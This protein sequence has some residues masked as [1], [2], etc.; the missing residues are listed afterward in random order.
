MG[1]SHR[2]SFLTLIWSSGTW[3]GANVWLVFPCLFFGRS[4]PSV[5]PTSTAPI[6]IPAQG[7]T[8][9]TWAQRPVECRGVGRAREPGVPTCTRALR[10]GRVGPHGRTPL[11][12]DGPSAAWWRQRPHLSV[13][14]GCCRTVPSCFSRVRLFAILWTVAC[15]APRSMGILQARTLRW[16]TVPSSRGS[17]RPGGSN[18]CLLRLP[19]C[20]QMP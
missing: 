18:P 9:G 13:G 7:E 12:G 15:R 6:I 17:F 5:F 10:A 14:E 16:V 1:I 19:R 11:P 3:V 20:R 8:P 4:I 2:M